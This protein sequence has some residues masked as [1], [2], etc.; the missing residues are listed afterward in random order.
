MRF[1]VLE[2]APSALSVPPLPSSVVPASIGYVPPLASAVD[3]AL[4]FDVVLLLLGPVVLA[5]HV[6]AVA[7]LRHLAVAAPLLQL[8]AF[9]CRLLQEVQVQ[10]IPPV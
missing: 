4:R 6:H 7:Q 2:P 8:F 5:R 9:Q 3:V 1:P 10:E